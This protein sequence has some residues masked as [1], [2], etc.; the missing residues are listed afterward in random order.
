L[1]FNAKLELSANFIKPEKLRQPERARSAEPTANPATIGPGP[2]QRLEASS[3]SA[4]STTI[5]AF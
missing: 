3:T 2:F 1:P 4:K 5:G